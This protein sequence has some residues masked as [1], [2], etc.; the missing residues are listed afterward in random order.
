LIAASEHARRRRQ[1]MRMTG[2]DAIIVVAAAPERV[3]SNDAHYPYRQDSDFHYLTGFPEPDAVLAL[4]PGRAQGE[5]I[6]FC[7]ERDAE[8]E[9]WDGRREGPEG[10]TRN[11]GMD[12]AFPIADIDEI[13]PGLIEGRT[14]VYYHFGRDTEFDLR[15]IGWVNRVRSQLKAGATPPHEFVALG[16]LLHDLRLYKSRAELRVMQRSARIAA[17]AQLRAMRACR[18]GLSEAAIEAELLHVYRSQHAVAAYEPIVGGGANACVLHYRANNAPLRAGDL[19]LV[20]AGAEYEGYAS[21]ITRTYPVNGRYSP[22]QRALYDVVLHAQQ[23][24]I[25]QLRP[26]RAYLDAHDAAV[27]TITRGLIK[28]GLLKGGLESNLK[29]EAYKAFFMHKTGHWIGLDVHDVGDYRVDGQPRELEPGMV[30][31][32]EPGVYVAP[33]AKGVDKRW[34]GIGIRIEDEV[35]VTR[36]GPQILT[37]DVP[38]DP[39]EIERVM[40]R[41]APLAITAG[42]WKRRARA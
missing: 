22:E 34:R 20:D 21:D 23:A 1:L 32:V 36:K 33:D 18:P 35:V 16:H 11:F 40:T 4:I 39:D 38:K 14:R 17:E 10:A 2:R 29:S 31:T 3:R 6:L 30:M 25:D 28:L 15:L 8:R 7:R 9:R 27:R 19:L 24:A 37:E 5:C 26:G 12:D 41:A 42:P 13:L